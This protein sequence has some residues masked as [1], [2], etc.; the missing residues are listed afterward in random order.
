MAVEAQQ[1]TSWSATIAGTSGNVVA[2]VSGS[3]T[4]I[5]RRSVD[6]C[7]NT[8][9]NH[10]PN[11]SGYEVCSEATSGWTR[12]VRIGRAP[13]EREPNPDR[14]SALELA[15]RAYVEKQD[16][17]VVKPEI[18]TSFDSLDEGFQFYNLY[19]WE[20]GFGV[21]FAKSRLNVERRKCMQEIVCSCAGAALKE[22][23]RSIRTGC[24]AMIRFLRS[25]DNGWYICEH[26]SDHNHQL[27]LTCGEKMHWKSHKHIDKYMKDIVKQLR[28]NNVS[29]GKVYS[30]IGSLFG[31]AKNVPFTK[32][33][34]KNLCRKMNKEQSDGD[35][36]KTMEI[37]AEM[38]ANDP[39]FNYA[40]QVD[41]ES[42]I[43]TLMW[44]TG[45]GC[46]QYRCFG[47]VITFDTTYRTNLY[48]MPFG[49]FV[50]VNNHFQSITFGGVMV[51]DEKVDTF[52]WVFREF[53]RMVGG[54]HPKTILTD[55]AR[56]MEIAIEEVLPNTVHR[57]CKWH[58]LRKAKESL[59]TLWTKNPNFRS[60][61]HKLVHHM[62]TVD[63]FE[64]GWNLMLDKY[65]LKK[66]PFLTQ[67][68]EVR[69]KWAKPFFMGVFCA[70]MTSTQ[71]SES[72][73]HLLKGYVPPGCPMHLFL[74]QFEKLQFDRES[75]ESYQEK[76]TSVGGVV[77]KLNIPLERHASKLYTRAMFEQFGDALYRSW[78]YVIEELEPA[79]VYLLTHRDAATREKWSKVNYKVI[80]HED[81]CF[82]ECECGSF[83]HA[84]M[85]CCHALKVMV[86][87]DIA[88]LP[89][90]HVLKR[91]TRN[92]R[93]VLPE[94]LQRYQKD[95]GPPRH[96]TY[97]HT[98]MYFKALECVQLGD[99]N[100]K[101][102][103]V[104]MAMMSQ[105]SETL[106]PLSLVKDGMGLAERE[107]A[108]AA[109]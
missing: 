108:N 5:L 101:C 53:I 73:N 22:N 87:L 81:K 62:I 51:R 8:T 100:V 99:S 57:W 21:R 84:G 15:L 76:R 36:T 44:V 38:K 59:G 86:H 78:A 30:I 43:K 98:K 37:L 28:Q 82:F 32:R 13:A 69:H 2:S 52:K 74:R 94:N 88:E 65:K 67:V 92:A 6:G 105:V 23:S 93:D 71:R 46:D 80:V 24:T 1:Q 29:L 56:S 91:W 68:Y 61:F 16:G 11:D 96:T 79:K 48:D 106:Q 33:S 50:G 72:A 83:E 58:V 104:F 42:R 64:C 85:I 12:R 34:L 66:H 102:Y 77:L 40:V 4:G 103:E 70:K 3:N 90:K 9:G 47:D 14:K 7:G 41:E 109:E 75:E 49:L 26:K 10:I 97:R 89:E 20:V 55:Q 25:A 17:V 39:E 27:S 45:R 35:A 60:E 95:N 63:E 31:V 107:A 18:G 19:S 54:K